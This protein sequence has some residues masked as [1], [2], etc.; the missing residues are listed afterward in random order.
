M[1]QIITLKMFS[2]ILIILSNVV[3]DFTNIFADHRFV[4]H[5]DDYNF[6]DC[7]SADHSFAN[8]IADYTLADCI[9]AD[10]SFDGRS[11]TGYY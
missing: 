4:N 11:L 2:K 1:V 6:A 7:M 9:P 5:N 3:S 8:R 10:R